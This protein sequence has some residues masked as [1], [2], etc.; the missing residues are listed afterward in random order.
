MNRN[1][2]CRPCDW[3]P[4]RVHAGVIGAVLALSACGNGAPGFAPLDEGAVILAFGDSLTYGTGAEPGESYPERLATRTG[5]TVIN[6]GIPGELSGEG[7]QRLAPL[8]S[9]HAP[10][11]VILWHGA[12]DILRNRD[13][14][15]T[16]ENLRAMVQSIRDAGAEV[17]LVSV[18]RKTVFLGPAPLYRRVA[19]EMD[20]ALLDDLL[21]E[22]LRDSSLKSDRVHPNGDGYDIVAQKIAEALE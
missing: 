7:R 13:L 22:I 17:L 21:P 20:V 3:F 11:L 15:V 10:D 12:N 2:A 6:A 5:F 19:E 18:P 9:R 16:E 4:R 1:R 14:A 8:L